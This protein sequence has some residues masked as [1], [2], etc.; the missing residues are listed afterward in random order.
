MGLSSIEEEPFA[1]RICCGP[2]YSPC[3]LVMVMGTQLHGGAAPCP[4][5]FGAAGRRQ[6]LGPACTL[7][8]R[9]VISWGKGWGRGGGLPCI[10]AC[11]QQAAVD[12]RRA[13]TVCSRVG[14]S[15]L[16]GVFAPS[17]AELGGQASALRAFVGVHL[18]LLIL[19]I[20]MEVA[21]PLVAHDETAL[22][23]GKR[24]GTT[25]LDTIETT[26]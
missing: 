8:G 4:A 5:T 7:R 13:W 20:I 25:P 2:S 9:S 6:P 1:A 18:A 23:N 10:T 24:D 15:I 22:L 14:E 26:L 19:L 12:C 11:T 3:M 17:L 21:A 16:A